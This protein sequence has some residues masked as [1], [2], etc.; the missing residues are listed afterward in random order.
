MA[1][2]VIILNFLQWILPKFSQHIISWGIQILNTKK[3]GFV[4]AG[5]LI[6]ANLCLLPLRK[7]LVNII[8]KNTDVFL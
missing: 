1:S 6:F 5:A 3:V 4:R 7:K 8:S 2:F